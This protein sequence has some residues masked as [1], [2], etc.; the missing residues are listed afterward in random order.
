MGAALLAPGTV[1]Q[2]S[3]HF[4][5]PPNTDWLLNQL[6]WV[7]KTGISNLKLHLPA[8][9]Q[10]ASIIARLVTENE[11]LKKLLD[12]RVDVQV[13]DNAVEILFGPGNQYRLLIPATTT[14]ER[15]A[16]A[17]ALTAAAAKLRA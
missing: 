1:M 7:T 13:Q 3:E 16:V 17:A 6:L 9:E 11:H 8:A 10:L 15:E 12:S 2:T 5:L 14:A 4:S